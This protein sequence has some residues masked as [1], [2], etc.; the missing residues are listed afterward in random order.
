M[1]HH[2]AGLR[3]L[4]DDETL[5]AQLQADWRAAE[6]SDA[7]KAMLAYAEKLTKTPWSMRESDVAALRMAGFS[8]AGILDI[9]QVVGYYAYANRLVDG[10]GV[11]LEKIHQ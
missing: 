2:G 1:T 8:D 9:N 4:T 11:E 7:D 5:A 6:I 10:L 3:K